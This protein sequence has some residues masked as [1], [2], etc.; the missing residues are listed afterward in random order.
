MLRSFLFCFLY[1]PRCN[2]SLL[3]RF[4]FCLLN[5]T[6]AVMFLKLS[7]MLIGSSCFY[8]LLEVTLKFMFKVARRHLNDVTKSQVIVRGRSSR[9]LIVGNEVEG[10]VRK[11]AHL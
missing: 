6:S 11:M 1:I 7:G 8:S 5:I 2:L 3:R 10:L 9:N 4:R